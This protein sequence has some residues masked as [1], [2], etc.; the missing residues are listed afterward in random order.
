MRF[1]RTC[2][3]LAA[4][5]VS[6]FSAVAQSSNA[7]A[8]GSAAPLAASVDY[9]ALRDTLANQSKVLTGDVATQRAILKKN[10]DLLKEAQKL[11]AAN[12]KMVAEKARMVQ[13]N[14]ELEKQRAALAQAQAPAPSQ[15]STIAKASTADAK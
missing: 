1:A 11:D 2:A 10:Q 12:K 14:A 13:Q 3:L 15:D 6:V 7:S 9:A 8:A 5:S 4:A